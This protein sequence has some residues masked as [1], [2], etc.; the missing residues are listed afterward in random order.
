L[1]TLQ[2]RCPSPLQGTVA[3]RQRAR[4]NDEWVS[5]AAGRALEADDAAGGA[6]ASHISFAENVVPT[7]GHVLPQGEHWKQTTLQAAL[8]FPGVVFVIFFSLNLLVWGQKSS[9]AVP[10][11]T[12]F[13][14]C[15]L[16]FGISVPLV[17]IG[18]YFGYKKQAPEVCAFNF[19]CAVKSPGSLM[20]NPYLRRAARLHRLLLRLQEAGA[21]GAIA[22][23]SQQHHACRALAIY[24]HICQMPRAAGVRWLVRKPAPATPFL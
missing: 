18:S 3:L 5:C 2:R 21:R 1:L 8:L 22:A 19:L 16:W 10:F 15:F 9:G 24:Q 11:S 12:L 6:A 7:S 13:A 23:A 4:K 14:L 20:P 17:F